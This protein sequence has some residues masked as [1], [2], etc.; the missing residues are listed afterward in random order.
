MPAKKLLFLLLLFSFVLRA[1]MS[2]FEIREIERSDFTISLNSLYYQTAIPYQ[3]TERSFII[4]NTSSVSQTISIKK[5]EILLNTLS[6]FDKAEA[7][8]CTGVTC[9]ASHI[10]TGAMVLN[11]GQ[12]AVFKAQLIEASTTGESIVSYKFSNNTTNESTV[13][14]IKY[15]SPL[16]GFSKLESAPSKLNSLKIYQSNLGKS[17]NIISSETLSNSILKIQ[18]TNGALIY[19]QKI[20]SQGYEAVISLES[21]AIHSGIYFASI[22]TEDNSTTK[23]IIIN[24]Q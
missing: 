15:N 5:S 19:S 21:I 18:D 23:K 20:G 22:I 16:A 7:F 17:L 10:F 8:F 6:N 11:A 24:K 13:I 3:T 14:T 2:T 1:Q 4:K 12:T 9:Y